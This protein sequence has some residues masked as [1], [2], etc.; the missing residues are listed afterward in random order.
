MY[1]NNDLFLILFDDYNTSNTVFIKE[2][3][4]YS[5]IIAVIYDI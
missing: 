5:T 3:D 2:C 4:S 1:F